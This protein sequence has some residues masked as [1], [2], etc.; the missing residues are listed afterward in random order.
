MDHDYSRRDDEMRSDTEVNEN[1]KKTRTRNEPDRRETQ[2]NGTIGNSLRAASPKINLKLQ[3]PKK[4]KIKIIKSENQNSFSSIDLNE[5]NVTVPVIIE[6]QRIKLKSPTH[7]INKNEHKETVPA[8]IQNQR[9]ELKSPTQPLHSQQIRQAEEKSNN[10]N[11]IV[12]DTQRLIQQMKDEINSDITSLDEGHAQTSQSERDS[13]SNDEREESSYSETDEET[14]NMSSDE[15]E[16][17]S[18]EDYEEEIVDDSKDIA[19]FPN[20]TSSEDNEQFEEAL[21]NLD[22]QIEDVKHANIEI[23]DSIARSLQEEH[24]I[25]VEI[26][27]P[28]VEVL[29]KNEEVNRIKLKASKNPD[30]NNNKKKFVTVN[31]FDEIYA[32]LNTSTNDVKEI[33]QLEPVPPATAKVTEIP[34]VTEIIEPKVLLTKHAIN[35]LEFK[36]VIPSKL[37]ISE[38]NDPIFSAVIETLEESEKENELETETTLVEIANNEEAVELITETTLVEIANNED[39]TNG[40]Q[41]SK[42]FSPSSDS[43]SSQNDDVLDTSNPIEPAV[44]TVE[45][46]IED[47]IPAPVADK[48]QIIEPAEHRSEHNTPRNSAEKVVET[49]PK[50][51]NTKTVTVKSNIPKPIKTTPNIKAKVDKLAPKVLASKVPVRRGSLKN[52]AP[53]PP[54]THFGNVQSGHVKQLQSKIF[55]DTTPAKLQKPVTIDVKPSTSTATLSKKKPAPQPPTKAEQNQAKQPTPPQ[56]SP[57]KEKKKYFRETCRTEDEWTDS[58]SEDSQ[59]Q[60]V[61]P[62]EIKEEPQAPPSPPPPPTVRRVSGQIIDL[63]TVQLPDGSPEVSSRTIFLFVHFFTEI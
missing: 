61:R 26:I 33:H 62:T 48:D 6:N 16:M 17:S 30:S 55:N 35:E 41:N 56:A 12:D 50:N 25:V 63:A 8:I 38:R 32:E 11:D 24:T 27:E 14:D 29:D 42:S 2:Q 18:T 7:L 52:P 53:A 44:E 58:E 59:S 5:H 45:I 23:L 43:E 21:D 22:N 36:I 47:P 15:K 34:P 60:V 31:S 39:L 51:E 40:R 46:K 57:P 37:L 19:T 20:R 4:A 49:P 13:S 28:V 54:K 9:N 3:E 1:F 10:L